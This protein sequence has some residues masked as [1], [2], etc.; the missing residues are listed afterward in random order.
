MI[1]DKPLT[2][3]AGNSRKATQWQAQSLYWSEMVERLRTPVRSTEK[4]SEY[5]RLPKTRQDDLKDVGGFVAGT[6]SGNR[7]KA[8]SVTCRDILTLDLDNIP[9]GGTLDILR[10]IDALQCNYAVYSTRKHEES[11]G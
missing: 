2:I 8:N 6:L 7:R 11:N 4:L 10:R 3:S 5:L 1:N 9:P